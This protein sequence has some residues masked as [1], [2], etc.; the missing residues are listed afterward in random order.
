MAANIDEFNKIVG[1]IFS[2]LYQ[3]FPVNLPIID[4]EAIAEAFEI[5]SGDMTTHKLPS[6][7]IFSNVLAHTIAW[8]VSQNYMVASGSH[9]AERVVLSDKGLA[10]LNAVP[11]KLSGSV[12]STLVK[13]TK[14]RN[15]GAVGE[16]VG[17]TIAG[18][19]KTMMGS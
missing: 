17:S 7:R 9:S 10:A 19:Q 13:E 11:E 6:G 18:Y 16:L 4:R 14:G 15:W 3:S 5:K 12:G 8:L 1:I 2:Q